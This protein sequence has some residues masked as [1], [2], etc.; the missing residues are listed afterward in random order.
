MLFAV[1]IPALA[2][3]DAVLSTGFRMRVER[4]EMRGDR[5][6]LYAR[7]GMT[8]LPASAVERFENVERVESADVPPPAVAN[9]LPAVPCGCCAI[10]WLST[11]ATG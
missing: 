6:I 9:P 1:A 11:T 4:H 10:F 3:E 8:E 7:G 5:V 2:A